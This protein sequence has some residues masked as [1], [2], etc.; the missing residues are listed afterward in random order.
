MIGTSIEWYDFFVYG[1]SVV[2]VLGPLFFPTTSPLT[3]TL[4]AFSTFGVGFLVR[5]VGAVVMSHI[6]D[7]VGRK[8]ALVFSLLLMGGA[9]AGVGLLPTYAVAGVWAPV[10]LVLLRCAQGFAVGG[11]WGGAVLLA[12][13]HAPPGRRGLYGTFPQ[14]G[15]G[16]GLLG[17]SA[18][19]LLAQR[20][21]ADDFEAWGWRLP[22]LVSLLLVGIGLW[23]RIRV[24]DAEEFLELRRTGGTLPS[25]VRSVLRHHWRLVLI[26]AA[27]TF[28]C[29][30][31]YILTSFLPAYASTELRVSD[32]A[33]LAGLMVG[34]VGS[35]AVLVVLARKL[36]RFDARRFAAA[37]GL[38]SALWIYPAFALA[39]AAAGPGL[40]IGVSVGLCVLM[41]QYAAVPALLAGQFPVEMRYSGVSLC[42][43]LSAVVGGGV[44]PV[45]VSWLVRT[46][47]GSYLPA[48]VVMVAAGLL[49]AVGALACRRPASTEPA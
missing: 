28:V 3:S 14:Y 15:T 22:F 36:D 47:G 6:G 37:G 20:M 32:D 38:L 19:I 8:R 41:V 9:T 25:P 31:A 2:L 30:A 5:P 39:D 21:P 33:A 4:L 16:F 48:V 35:I 7:R 18:A 49:T 10:L 43:Q 11:E 29:H 12:V 13:E 46:A 42:F 27:A 34:S 44:V 1:T 24:I 23:V 17:S 40:V 26:G 45:L